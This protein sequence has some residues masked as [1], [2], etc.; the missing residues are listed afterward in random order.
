MFFLFHLCHLFFLLINV[1]YSLTPNWNFISSTKNLL[2]DSSTSIQIHYSYFWESHL[3]LNHTYSKN[4]SGIFKTN[5]LKIVY[6]KTLSTE[7]EFNDVESYYHTKYDHHFFFICPKGRNNIKNI[8]DISNFQ[9]LNNL[10]D[11]SIEGEYELHCIY[12]T[13]KDANVLF[14]ALQNNPYA[15]NLYG[16]SLRNESFISYNIGNSILDYIM[17]EDSETNN[18]LIICSKNN[19]IQLKSLCIKDDNNLNLDSSNEKDIENNSFSINQ[20]T[21]Y[22]NGANEYILYYITYD[23]NSS[24]YSSG[25]SSVSLNPSSKISNLEFIKNYTL[26]LEFKNN[27]KIYSMDLVPKTYFVKYVVKVDEKDPLTEIIKEN[28][29][30]GI[31]NIETNKV[32]FNTDTIIKNF[33]VSNSSSNEYIIVTE[34]SVY[35][36]CGT[37]IYNEKCVYKCNDNLIIDYENKNYC[38]SW[39][40]KGT[41]LMPYKICIGECKTSL[42]YEKKNVDGNKE[43]GLCRDLNQT[44]NYKVYE[45]EQCISNSTENIYELY[46]SLNIYKRCYNTC[47]KCNGKG[48][49]NNHNC[50][51]CIDNYYLTDKNCDI[52]CRES[53]YKNETERKCEKCNDNCLNCLKGKEGENNYCTSCK[54][55]YYLLNATGYGQNCVQNCPE[56]TTI[57]EKFC[58]DIEIEEEEERKEEEVEEEEREKGE[59]EQ[60]KDENKEDSNKN[61]NINDE[62]IFIWFIIL[63][64]LIILVFFI[65]IYTFYMCKP[66]ISNDTDEEVNTELTQ[67]NE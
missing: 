40:C 53:Y 26:P 48:D 39:N 27:T 46:P 9:K 35:L 61:Q 24:N 60:K 66:E 30:H 20:G 14:Y 7:V 2:T 1:S 31:I 23:K 15:E 36:L 37:A 8:S 55:N 5:N 44:H 45:E 29:Y 64:S 41:V 51:K 63:I 67:F 16:F 3:F 65:I 10:T 58:V 50:I 32:I 43:C 18:I 4:E 52:E 6:E 42:F 22:K 11:I 12:H 34:N 28:T 49:E 17:T 57:K 19:T 54:D 21:F 25:Y 56:N 33:Y 13:S 59:E 62:N 38:G 47:Q